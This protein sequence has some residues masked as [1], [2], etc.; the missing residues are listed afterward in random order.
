[1]QHY[2]VKD[3]C[4]PHR[5][6]VEQTFNLIYDEYAYLVF[7][8]ALEILQNSEDAKDVT[9][10][11][12]RKLYEKRSTLKSNKNL[13]YYLVTIAKNLAINEHKKADRYVH[14]NDDQ[15]SGI[16]EKVD[17]FNDYLDK[18]SAFLN[19]DEVALVVYRFL[20]EYSFKEIAALQK[21]T[22][23]SVSSKYKRTLHKIRKH[24]GREE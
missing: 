8:V 10:E 11:T 24:Y 19:K 7:F 17:D 14:Y 20:Y 21:T 22:I 3:L 6:T 9:N 2:N 5:E 16:E 23:N 1:M 15:Y 12:F 4:S 18:F 13:K